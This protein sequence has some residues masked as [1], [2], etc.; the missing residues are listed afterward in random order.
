ML[1][2]QLIQRGN[3]EEK[4][5]IS[6]LSQGSMDTHEGS[7]IS[8]VVGEETNLEDE[9]LFTAEDEEDRSLPSSVHGSLH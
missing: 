4:V 2:Q 9:P 5:E 6:L 7:E 3:S 1:L 8:S